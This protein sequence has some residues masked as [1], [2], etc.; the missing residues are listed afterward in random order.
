MDTDHGPLGPCVVNS[1]LEVVENPVCHEVF[2][3]NFF[4][5]VGLLK[6]L[7]DQGFKAIG[8]IPVNRLNNTPWPPTKSNQKKTRGLIEVCSANDI[9]AVRWFDNKVVTLAS[10]N[11]IHE[12][13]QHLQP[14]LPSEEAK[15]HH[16]S[17]IS[18]KAVQ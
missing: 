6:S 18:Y 15:I 2:F 17:T 12:L 3:D 14:V 16:P 9:C 11:L 4:T 5:S 10:N 13:L 7:R 1:L 8:S